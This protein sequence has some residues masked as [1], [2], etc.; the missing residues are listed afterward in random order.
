MERRSLLRAAVAG[1]VGVPAGARLLSGTASAAPAGPASYRVLVTRVDGG[2]DRVMEFDRNAP[3][4]TAPYVQWELRPGWGDVLEARCRTSAHDGDVVLVTAGD[5][6]SK[7][8]AGIYRKKDKKLLW[9]VPVGNYPHSIELIRENGAVVVAGAGTKRP[10][11]DAPRPHGSIHL[12]TTRNGRIGTL[13]HVTSY[14][15][16]EAHGVLWDPAYKLL[17]AIGRTEIRRYRLVGSGAGVR[18]REVGADHR[19]TIGGNGH[20]LQP[21]YTDKHRLLLTDSRHVYEMDKRTLKPTPLPGPLGNR[22]HVKS[23]VRHHSGEYMWAGVPDGSDSHFGGPD[24]HFLPPAA[25]RTCG[26]GTVTYK[27]RIATTAY[28]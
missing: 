11:P 2:N 16:T 4:F 19:I 17:W 15:L 14:P 9:S 20:D 24:I 23:I 22:K 25:H 18:L 13:S 28:Q 5:S 6:P 26:K 10:R 21:D 12:Y 8:R 27:A 1:V 7:G 3:S